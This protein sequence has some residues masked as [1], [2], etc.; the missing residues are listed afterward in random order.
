MG[1]VLLVVCLLGICVVRL[2]LKRGGTRRLP[3]PPPAPHNVRRA[4]GNGVMFHAAQDDSDSF[5]SVQ[6]H[7]YA[8][9]PDDTDLSNSS[10]TL[11]SLDSYP[12]SPVSD[13]SMSDDYLH[14]I[15]CPSSDSSLPEDYLHPVA[16]EEVPVATATAAEPEALCS[17][18][19]V[20]QSGKMPTRAKNSIPKASATRHDRPYENTPNRM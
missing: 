4:A 5:I 11:T 16:S 9:I 18:K 7:E 12:Q 2:Y 8:E 14:H 15:A 10:R 17:A 13:S 3:P 20:M 1:F 19:A 6:G